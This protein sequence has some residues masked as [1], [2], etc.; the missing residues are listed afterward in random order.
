MANEQEL[1]ETLRRQTKASEKLQTT[2]EKQ[3]KAIA[4]QTA[5]LNAQATA[6]HALADSLAACTLEDADA[7]PEAEPDIVGPLYADGTPVGHG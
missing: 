5:A 3:T 2:I 4:A 6:V 1:I 7:K